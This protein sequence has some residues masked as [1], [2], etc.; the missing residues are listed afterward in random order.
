MRHICA[1][2]F[3][4]LACV[5]FFAPPHDVFAVTNV[6]ERAALQ[7][8][9]DQIERDIAGNQGTLSELQK[10]RTSLERSIAIL[11]NKIKTAQLQIKQSD[12]TL[13]QIKESILDK[14]SAIRE[15][16][17][18]VMRGERSVAQ[19]LRRTREIDDLSIAELALGKNLDD[20]FRD[21][22]DFQTIQKALGDSFMEMAV[23]REDLNRRKA[24]LED[25]QDE[26]QKV[27]TIQVLA[28]AA[29]Q[30]DETEKKN[31]L[32]AT[33]GQEKAYQQLIANKQKQAAAIRTALFGLRD[34]SA[35]PFGTAY[36]YAKQATALTRVRP[37]LILAIL[38]Q[39]SDLGQNVGSCYVSNILKG[40]GIG[41][42]TGKV[43]S[44]VMKAP[45]DTQPFRQITESLGRDWSNTPVSCPQ[46]SGYGGA[47]GPSQFISSTWM[48]YKSRLSQLT[49]EPFPDPWNPRTAI[50]AT[51]LLMKDN[52]AD[53]GTRANERRAALKYFAGSNWNK[54]AN[55]FYGDSV[56]GLADKIQAEIDIL[57]Q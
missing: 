40:S 31:I 41:K 55:A 12:L 11:D 24:D 16:D 25:K 9:L 51:A 43:F 37:A 27:R 45:R 10:A 44:N 23:L 15:V 39:E 3:F 54:A 32:S 4:V 35:I 8:Q 50:F 42:N 18:K 19:L 33:K 26:A 49:S 22:D 7:T 2:L 56:M 5:G 20:F 46:G 6:E 38:T 53:G 28:K 17:E 30:K 47:M 48:L 52:G 13:S 14:Q 1:S 21:I 34:S 57:N 36:D 29:I